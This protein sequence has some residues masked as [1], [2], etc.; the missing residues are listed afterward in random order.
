[1]HIFKFIFQITHITDSTIVSWL[2]SLKTTDKMARFFDQIL[3]WKEKACGS[4]RQHDT[5]TSLCV[6]FQRAEDSQPDRCFDKKGVVRFVSRDI[7]NHPVWIP[8]RSV[9]ADNLLLQA[10]HKS[11]HRGLHMSLAMIP[12]YLRIVDASRHMRKIISKCILC[13]MIRAK[14]IRQ[15]FGPLHSNQL[16]FQLP[17]EDITTDVF[18]PMKLR[19]GSKCYGLIVICRTS[20]AIKLIVLPS[21]SGSDLWTALEMVWNQ[22]GWP[23][24]IW[25]DNGFNYL[26]VKNKIDR[27]QNQGEITPNPMEFI[28]PFRTVDEWH[29]GK[30]CQM[31][32]QCALKCT[33]LFTLQQ[34]FYGIESIANQRPVLNSADGPISAFQIITGRTI[35]V[36]RTYGIDCAESVVQHRSKFMSEM[37][38]LWVSQLIN[39]N[40]RTNLVRINLNFLK[41]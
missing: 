34:R 30:T 32:S 28:N 27:L 31:L 22:V 4:A 2:R 12:T 1:M 29:V 36:N 9:L 40:P 13:R 14:P 19:N 8:K 5:F 15:P 7:N 21:L 24:R 41:C 38:R 6:A 17:F 35:Q 3:K 26:D 20:K 11:K 25:S 10:H 37:Q 33:S 23:R 39:Q 18:R 16:I